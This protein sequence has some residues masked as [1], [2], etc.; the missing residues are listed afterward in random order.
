MQASIFIKEASCLR[1]RLS[2]ARK[3]WFNWKKHQD[4]LKMHDLICSSGLYAEEE[5][6]MIV[7]WR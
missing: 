5:E 7:D 3:E 2:F 4:F 6:V 1:M